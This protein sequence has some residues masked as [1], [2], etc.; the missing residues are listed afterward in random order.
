MNG[1]LLKGDWGG[2]VIT[3][4]AATTVFLVWQYSKA[5]SS[6]AVSQAAEVAALEQVD[7]ANA[8]LE[9]QRT[10]LDS[11]AETDSLEKEAYADSV[12]EWAAERARLRSVVREEEAHHASLADSVIARVDSTTAEIVT[13]MQSSHVATMMV[14]DSIEASK[15]IQIKVLGTRVLLLESTVSVLRGTVELLDRRDLARQA[16]GDALRDQISAQKKQKRI[17]I[18]TVV[19]LGVLAVAR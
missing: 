18:A 10:T 14:R 2:P 17:A 15:D 5:D 13:R 1:L 11:L 8:L 12:A 4:L 19:V 9:I 6:L 3:I 7:S 16:V